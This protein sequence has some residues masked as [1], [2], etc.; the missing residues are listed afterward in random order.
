MSL[1]Y[2]YYRVEMED[3]LLDVKNP[4][5]ASSTLVENASTL[6][7]QKEVIA[8]LLKH[9]D[10]ISL[11]HNIIR[12]KYLHGSEMITCYESEDGKYIVAEGNRR[13]CAC[14]LLLNRDLIPLEYADHFPIA[15]A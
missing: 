8:H 5:F 7:G 3:L 1:P 14:K 6:P 10:V 12:T 9:S 13:V 15:D 4:R 11:A 2:E